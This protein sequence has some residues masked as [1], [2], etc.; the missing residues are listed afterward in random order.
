MKLKWVGLSLFLGV[1]MAAS[2]VMLWA[3]GNL[4]PLFKVVIAKPEKELKRF[5]LLWQ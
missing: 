1:V 3:K 4:F 2:E 5:L